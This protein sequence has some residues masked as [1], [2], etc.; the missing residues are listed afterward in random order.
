MQAAFPDVLRMVSG[1]D[2]ARMAAQC[3]PTAMARAEFTISHLGD[4]TARGDAYPL[5]KPLH[6]TWVKGSARHSAFPTT[7]MHC[8]TGTRQSTQNLRRN[9]S[10]GWSPLV[11]TC[12]EHAR[13]Y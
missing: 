9:D 6:V 11:F 13:E 3:M 10:E 7:N 12:R 1:M 4:T 8:S 2:D 5:G